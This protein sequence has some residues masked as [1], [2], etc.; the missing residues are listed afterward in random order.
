MT[1][2]SKIL[3]I[4]PSFPDFKDLPWQ[5]SLD[6]WGDTCELIENLPRAVSRHTVIY[7]RYNGMRFALK[8]LPANIA[9][10][11]YANLLKMEESRLPAVTPVGYAEINLPTLRSSVLITRYLERSIPYRSLISMEHMGRYRDHLLDGIASLLVQLH[12]RGY[13]WGDCSFSNTL[14]RRDA[15]ELQAYLVDAE[16]S[17]AFPGKTPPIYRFDD[18]IILDA[19]LD[20]DILDLAPGNIRT[21]LELKDIG[22]YIRLQYQKLWEEITKEVNLQSRETYRVQ[23]R[24]R[25]LNNLGFS[26]GSVDLIKTDQG[27]NLRLQVAVT[28]R[29]YHRDQLYQFTG[30]CTE[31]MQAKQMINE[32]HELKASLA[33]SENRNVTLNEAAAYWLEN[34]YKPTLTKLRPFLNDITDPAE[35]YCQVLENKWYL[36]ERARRD[37]GHCLATEDYLQNHIVTQVR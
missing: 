32:I 20:T 34:Y 13:Y 17:I 22:A 26:I 21:Q 28:D 11:E 33:Q 9:R 23:E 19:N 12:L 7:L 24:I 16:T 25:A 10:E 18:L 30:L 2:Y 37:V 8:E 35:L 4:R 36:S 27:E 31:E 5:I 1:S 6:K 29:N 3:Y 14:F 15:G